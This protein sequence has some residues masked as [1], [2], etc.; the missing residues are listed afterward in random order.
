MHVCSFL[1][2]NKHSISKYISKSDVPAHHCSYRLV[3]ETGTVLINPVLQLH[4]TIAR[5][6]TMFTPV[7]CYTIFICCR[8]YLCRVPCLWHLNKKAFFPF[9]CIP[10]YRVPLYYLQDVTI[11][12]TTHCRGTRNE[13]KQYIFYTGHHSK[14]LYHTCF[15]REPGCNWWSRRPNLT[16]T[17]ISDV[18]S[19]IYIYNDEAK[20]TLMPFIA[21]F[22]FGGGLLR[23]PE[24]VQFTMINDRFNV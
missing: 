5:F 24:M 8:V 4:L 9:C 3:E 23:G 14:A 15:I 18:K 13:S 7:K 1:K 2:H 19:T 16:P 17:V 10:V 21:H 20:P 22:F 12:F 11:L 6:Y